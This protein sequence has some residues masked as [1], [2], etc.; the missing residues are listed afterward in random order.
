MVYGVWSQAWDLA[1]SAVSI[2]EVQG[3]TLQWRD[4][5]ECLLPSR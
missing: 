1:H 5:L 4:G 2:C 3:E